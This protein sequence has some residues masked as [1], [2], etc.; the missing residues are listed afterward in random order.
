MLAIKFR[1]T[2]LQSQQFNYKQINIPTKQ[3]PQQLNG[4]WCFDTL[5]YDDETVHSVSVD[6]LW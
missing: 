3:G 6:S 5:Y 4:Q 1:K 2:T